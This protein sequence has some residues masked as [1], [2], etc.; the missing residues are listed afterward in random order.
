M[1]QFTQVILTKNEQLLVTNTLLCC[2]NRVIIIKS[3]KY[4]HVDAQNIKVDIQSGDHWASDDVSYKQ[5]LLSR[6]HYFKDFHLCKCS[7]MHY[8]TSHLNLEVSWRC[9]YMPPQTLGRTPR[10]GFCINTKCSKAHISNFT[11]VIALLERY[12]RFYYTQCWMHVL[13]THTKKNSHTVLYIRIIH[14]M[15]S[16]VIIYYVLVLLVEGWATYISSTAVCTRRQSAV[17]IYSI[18]HQGAMW[19]TSNYVT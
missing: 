13:H 7:T 8:W 11:I 3:Y 19:S 6:L 5:L 14:Q 15:Y 9:R 1:F 17:L 12:I 4:V 16:Q 18:M 10:H 2:T